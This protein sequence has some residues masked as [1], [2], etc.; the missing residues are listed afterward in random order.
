MSGNGTAVTVNTTAA[1]NLSTGD[2]VAI[3]G[4]SVS[5]FNGN[6][7]ITKTSS[8]QFTFAS[9]TSGTASAPSYPVCKDLSVSGSSIQNITTLTCNGTTGIAVVSG[10]LQ[11]GMQTGDMVYI[12][13]ASPVGLNGYYNIT[14]LSNTSFSFACQTSTVGATAVMTAQE[15]YYSGL[16]EIHAGHIAYLPGGPR[17]YGDTTAN[18]LG[19]SGDTQ[20]SLDGI[21]GSAFYHWDV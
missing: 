6:F 12:Q 17:L 14:I 9:T 4:S 11:T 20:C 15:L 21:Y 16:G 8:T 19:W 1:H 2:Y 13:N 5:A 10:G 3:A 18:S 7:Y